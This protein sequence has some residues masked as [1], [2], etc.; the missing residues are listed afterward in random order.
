M[1][2]AGPLKVPESIFSKLP[3]DTRQPLCI[4]VYSLSFKVALRDE[5][6]THSNF[7]IDT[8]PANTRHVFLNYRYA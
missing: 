4:S 7:L 6:I 8:F 2:S 5:E 3:P 1:T